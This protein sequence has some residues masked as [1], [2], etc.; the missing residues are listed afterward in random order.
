MIYLT[1]FGLLWLLAMVYSLLFQEGGLFRR[2]PYTAASPPYYIG[3]R[4]E[5]PPELTFHDFHVVYDFTEPCVNCYFDNSMCGN[6]LC[7]EVRRNLGSCLTKGP[8][9]YELKKK[10]SK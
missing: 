1:I 3:I 5:S 4:K 7:H 9:H 6:T 8:V 10:S 2:K